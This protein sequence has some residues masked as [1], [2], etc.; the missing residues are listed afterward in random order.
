MYLI[1]FDYLLIC[2]LI[3]LFYSFSVYFNCLYFMQF[4]FYNFNLKFKILLYEGLQIVAQLCAVPRTVLPS[5]S[6]VKFK[7][8][9]P[10]GSQVGPSKFYK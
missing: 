4:D 3:L 8:K 5:R 2:K 1:F 10:R 7:P 6:Q 9:V